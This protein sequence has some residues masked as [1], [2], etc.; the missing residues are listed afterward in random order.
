MLQQIATA[1]ADIAAFT[2]EPSAA[3]VANLKSADQFAYMLKYQQTDNQ[4]SAQGYKSSQGPTG[5]AALA[6]GAEQAKDSAEQKV[7]LPPGEKEPSV[8]ENALAQETAD[9]SPIGLEDKPVEGAVKDSHNQAIS[10]SDAESVDFVEENQWLLLMEK[11]VNDALDS[12]SPSPDA[13]GDNLSSATELQQ[14]ASEQLNASADAEMSETLRSL[15]DMLSSVL[16]TEQKDGEIPTDLQQEIKNLLQQNPKISEAFAQLVEL[17]KQTAAGEQSVLPDQL[18]GAQP[19]T[20]ILPPQEQ[21][22]L[23]V[24]LAES[25]FSSEDP[26]AIDQIRDSEALNLLPDAALK[27]II[28]LPKDKLDKVLA[29]LEQKLS[30]GDTTAKMINSAATVEQQ[31]ANLGLDNILDKTAGV[32]DFVAALKTGIAEVKAQ[33]SQGREP[34]IDLKGLINEALKT[35]GESGAS[36]V[37]KLPEQLD[38]TLKAFNQTLEFAQQLNSTLDQSSQFN[39]ANNTLRELSQLQGEQVKSSQLHTSQS[40]TSQLDKA[41]NL[42]KPEALQQLTEKV[43]WMVNQRQLV[44]DIRLDPAELG[45]MQV[46]VSLA[47]ESANVSFVVNSAQAKDAVDNA[48]P[49]LREMLAE[50]GIELGQSSV[51]QEQNNQGQDQEMAGHGQHSGQEEPEEGV[52]HDQVI[53]QPI[54]NG[55][56]GGIDYFV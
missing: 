37:V 10:K 40:Q 39:A 22:L 44:A 30:A 14:E 54:V 34:G 18:I 49:R 28:Q 7:I 17:H 46:K 19:D 16:G 43:R 15:A 52:I 25:Q 42:A 12:R 41:L 51:E 48:T 33:L 11:L 27:Q 3:D 29:Y 20:D 35:T 47:G 23:E 38:L 45:S 55:A 53:Q 36:A 24:L 4:R 13:A 6:P 8:S 9:P 56:L 50:K 21:K 26:V 5:K 1:N 31:T 32:S 2:L